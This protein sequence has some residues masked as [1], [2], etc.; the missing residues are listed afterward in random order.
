MAK[1]YRVVNTHDPRSL[2]TELNALEGDGKDGWT[3]HS[4]AVW[5]ERNLVAV[6]VR[7]RGDAKPSPEEEAARQAKREQG[8]RGA[9]LHG[10]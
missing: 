5:S 1:E 9:D 2:E 6:L 3:L 10:T 4:V 8:S 7:E